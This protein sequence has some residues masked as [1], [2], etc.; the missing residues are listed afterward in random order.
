MRDYYQHLTTKT[1]SNH[2]PGP[3]IY[4][5][6]GDA[7]EFCLLRERE[8][9]K[10]DWLVAFRNNGQHWSEHQEANAKLIAAAPDMIKALKKISWL[11]KNMPDDESDIWSSFP[12]TLEMISYIRKLSRRAIKKATK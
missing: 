11:I 4:K 8:D 6:Q 1:M 7:Q 9:G 2:T 10:L 5:A 3:W 12:D